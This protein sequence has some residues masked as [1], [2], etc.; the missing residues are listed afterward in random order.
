[1]DRKVLKDGSVSPRC[2]MTRSA[3]RNERKSNI[4]VVK[5]IKI[6]EENNDTLIGKTLSTI[7]ITNSD[8]K[9]K[10]K[11][12]NEENEILKAF[13]IIKEQK[14]IY[15]EILKNNEKNESDI[16]VNYKRKKVKNN[17]I[18]RE[19]I[20]NKERSTN[21]KE[22]KA[23]NICTFN[24]KGVYKNYDNKKENERTKKTTPSI[25][26]KKENKNVNISSRGRNRILL[27]AEKYNTIQELINDARIRR[28]MSESNR[29]H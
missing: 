14:K 8:K 12:D 7:N 26:A 24:D 13:E 11:S 22:E 27:G 28:M 3:I 4:E 20:S 6:Y 23:Q 9:K 1:M 10:I 21:N 16:A 18:G 19:I 15:E 25:V 17:N 2:V 29:R 5:C